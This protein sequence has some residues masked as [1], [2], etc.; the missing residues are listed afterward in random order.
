MC[1]CNFSVEA[2]A[3]AE[4]K[5]REELIASPLQEAPSA[6]EPPSGK[7]KKKKRRRRPEESASANSGK[8]NYYFIFL[9]YNIKIFQSPLLL[10]FHV[11]LMINNFL[12]I[13]VLL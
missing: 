10:S 6:A 5:Q 1:F 13:H 2:E 11:Q 3:S 4:K 8:L 7:K 12:L 9:N